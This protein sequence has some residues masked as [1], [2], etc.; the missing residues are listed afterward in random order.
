MTPHPDK[1]W[2]KQM[3]RNVTMELSGYCWY[4]L[5]DRDGRFCVSFD[6][7]IESGKIKPI[8]L[9]SQESKLKCYAERWV[10]SVKEN[11]LSK[12]ILFGEAS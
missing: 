9:A 5:H 7:I 12:L 11:C 2:M 4:L 6:E 3:A 1:E 10:R 8:S